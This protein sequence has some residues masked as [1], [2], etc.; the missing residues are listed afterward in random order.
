MTLFSLSLQNLKRKPFRTYALALAVAIASG[1]V[2]STATV[3]WGVERSLQ[4]GFSKFG[5]DLMVLPKGALVSMKAALLTGEPSTFYMDEAQTK[6]IRTLSGV[7]KV[8][9]QV[10][11]TT[12]DGA[13]CIIGNAFV[14]GFDPKTDFTVL[15]WLSHKLDRPLGKDDAIVGGV[16]PYQIGE[17]IFFYGQ[18][19]TVYGKLDKTGIGL[20][21]NAI[22]ITIEKAYELSE[23]SKKRPDVVPLALERGKV[24][25]LLVQL[26]ST[27]KANL[28]RFA[29]SKNPQVKVVTAGNVITSVRQNL[30]ALFSGT[31]ILS[32]VLVVGNILMIS[33]IFSTIINERRK[34]LGLLRAIGA[35][36]RGIFQLVVSESVLLTTL[37]GVLGVAVG[38]VL[39]RVYERTIVFHLE[40]LSIPFLWPSWGSIGG[41]ALACVALS[42]LVGVLGA[43]YPALVGSRM[44]PYDAIRAGE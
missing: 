9:P 25:T 14:V 6:E 40:S 16:N 7:A 2:F 44:E 8:S 27:A 19:L 37:G 41:V 1:A 3:M 30:V 21:D 22:F 23:G 20:Y 17:N 29:I 35:K 18:N 13:C 5:A 43:L 39:L 32:G 36:K 26:G 4:V 12:A 31:V 10:F 28:V 24:S 34:E 33:A 42:L 38:G 15:P 11:L